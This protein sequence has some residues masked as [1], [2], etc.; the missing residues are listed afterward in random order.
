VV[1]TAYISVKDLKQSLANKDTS[2]KNWW[3]KPVQSM[4]FGL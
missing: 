3:F 1:K 4:S 2:K